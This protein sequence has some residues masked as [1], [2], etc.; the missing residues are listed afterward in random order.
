MPSGQQGVGQ[1]PSLQLVGMAFGVSVFAH[2]LFPVSL[3]MSQLCW[4]AEVPYA[5][6]TDCHRQCWEGLMKSL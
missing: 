1:D 3:S 2:S 6:C 4:G 5:L